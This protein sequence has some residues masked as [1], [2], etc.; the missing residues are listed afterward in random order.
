MLYR[1]VSAAIAAIVCLA[2]SI[3]CGSGAGTLPS[4][5][6]GLSGGAEDGFEV[7]GYAQSGGALRR[8]IH[9][10]Y[11]YSRHPS[12]NGFT[13]V[14]MADEFTPRELSNELALSV[15]AGQEPEITLSANNA[16]GFNAHHDGQRV[17]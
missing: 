11:D 10:T 8:S 16:A 17:G 14:Q 6:S 9:Y 4:Q 12:Q 1:M 7:T 13:L 5:P 15:G 2:T 3:G